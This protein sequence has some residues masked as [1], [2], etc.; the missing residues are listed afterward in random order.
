MQA[1]VHTRD[2]DLCYQYFAQHFPGHAADLRRALAMVSAPLE[3]ANVLN[4]YLDTVGGW[5]IAQAE[6]WLDQYNP[7][8]DTAPGRKR[9]Y[10]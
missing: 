3:D 1:G 9:Y 4:D 2:V 5:L 8:R 7:P 6:Q 10:W